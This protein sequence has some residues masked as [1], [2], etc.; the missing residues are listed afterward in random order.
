MSELGMKALLSIG[1]KP[2]PP[3]LG[4]TLLRFPGPC[5]FAEYSKGAMKKLGPTDAKYVY[6][7]KNRYPDLNLGIQHFGVFSVF[8]SDALQ[9][10]KIVDPSIL[11]ELNFRGD[12]K[13]IY[14]G[15]NQK[16]SDEH[17]FWMPPEMFFS[18]ED[19]TQTKSSEEMK[20]F[21]G[22]AYEHRLQELKDTVMAYMEEVSSLLAT[23]AE[24]PNTAWYKVDRNERE[25]LLKTNQIKTRWV[26]HGSFSR[27]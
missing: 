15:L 16:I 1:E 5:G 13:D 11:K 21:F 19:W 26:P 18:S 17:C 6:L 12:E 7:F 2:A 27:F 20:K 9:A 14:I 25:R 3:E 22:S 8:K 4:Q 10:M 23:G 24:L